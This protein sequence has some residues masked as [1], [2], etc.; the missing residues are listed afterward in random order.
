MPLPSKEYSERD[1]K[2]IKDDTFRF[3][4]LYAIHEVLDE[5]QERVSQIEKRVI[6]DPSEH[7]E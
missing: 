3:V 6:S 2:S 1:S 5:L 4:T 7:N